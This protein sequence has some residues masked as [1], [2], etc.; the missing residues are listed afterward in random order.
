M[1]FDAEDL[2]VAELEQAVRSMNMTRSLP[3]TPYTKKHCNEKPAA[4][5]RGSFSGM[6]NMLNSGTPAISLSTL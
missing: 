1:L 4:S 2:L 3:T 5:L 6:Q